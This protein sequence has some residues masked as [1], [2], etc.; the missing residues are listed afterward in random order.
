L[1]IS[2]PEAVTQPAKIEQ[3][4]MDTRPD[5][6]TGNGREMPRSLGEVVVE[7]HAKLEDALSQATK[8]LDAAPDITQP[9]I[10]V[11]QPAS[12]VQVIDRDRQQT[13]KPAAAIEQPGNEATEIIA[14]SYRARL[15]NSPQET[16]ATDDDDDSN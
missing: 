6:T 2:Q 14:E 15:N 8:A 9:D 16:E 4:E 1:T 5:M 3:P 12:M 13:V 7:S 10:G 11:A